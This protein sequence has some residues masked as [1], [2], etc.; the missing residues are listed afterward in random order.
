MQIYK[1]MENSV[2]DLIQSSETYEEALGNY[3]KQKLSFGHGELGLAIDNVIER[4]ITE[5]ALKSKVK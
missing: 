1:I 5:R 3:K 2:D 4:K